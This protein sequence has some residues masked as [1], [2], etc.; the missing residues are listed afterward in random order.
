VAGYVPEG[1]IEA[2]LPALVE[3]H[4]A[5]KAMFI[6]TLNVTT[7]HA[8]TKI[9]VIPALSE[10]TLDCRLLPGGDAEDWRQQVVERIGD[11]RIEVSNVRAGPS[12][13][14]LQCRD[15]SLQRLGFRCRRG[16]SRGRSHGRRRVGRRECGRHG[17][18]QHCERAR[19]GC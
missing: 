5:L 8:G 15:F 6:N 18:R 4:P 16:G 14:R 1:D 13:L 19:Q 7:I 3:D 17:G 12:L 11:P 10:A 9:N 2:L